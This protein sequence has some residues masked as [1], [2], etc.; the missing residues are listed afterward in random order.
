MKGGGGGNPGYVPRRTTSLN[1]QQTLSA[2]A[3]YW[4]VERRTV[5]VILILVLLIIVAEALT[6]VALGHLVSAVSRPDANG[7]DDSFLR[8]FLYAGGAMVT[9]IIL[10]QIL[11]RL[12]NGLTVR[13][14]QRLQL[15]LFARV[16]RLSADWHSNS[17]TGATVHRISRARWALDMMSTIIIQRLLQP[18][19]LTLVFGT[20]ICLTLPIAGLAFFLFT[21]LYL[22]ASWILSAKWVRPLGVLSAKSDSRL[23]GAMAD[24][25]TNNATVRA[26][27]AERREDDRLRRISDDWCNVAAPSFS[28]ATDTNA[29]QMLLWVLT[30]LTVLGAIAWQARGQ[31]NGTA[32]FAFAI[33]A[34]LLLSGQLRTLGQDIR[35]IQRAYAELEDAAEFLLADEV[36]QA[37][38]LPIAASATPGE[39]RFERVG[40]AYPSGK[41]V[42]AD[43]SFTIAAGEQVALVGP[44]GSGKSTI[45]RLVQRLYVPQT[46]VILIDGRD[47]AQMPSDY[48][49]SIISLVPQEPILFHRSLAENIAYGRPNASFEEI[50][51]AAKRARAHDFIAALEQGYDSIV[52]E[53]GAKLSG[54]E[55]QRVAIARAIL[56]DRPILLL[57]EATSS[58]DTATERQVQEAIRELAR[59]RTTIII[60]HRLST[61]EHVDR[62]LVFDQGQIVEQGNHDALMAK[63]S[64][65]YRR[66]FELAHQRQDA[67][68]C[69]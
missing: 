67:L 44:S 10:K 35:V 39:I 23:T 14:M 61:V 60:A 26:F 62:I 69:D 9:A 41:D 32:D 49:G 48:L 55:R 37:K 20:M 4:L 12:W 33:S 38:P 66:S 27:A 18:L 25:I 40:F 6:P 7:P 45:V 53:R 21:S 42:Y 54:G 13:S 46:G 68:L 16:Q 8:Y 31:Q 51:D 17:F 50:V 30:Q 58:L 57:D 36:G 64:G 52:G 34:L 15:D 29:I 63:Q 1:W 11:D 56:A 28:R 5:A 24:A 65:R 19:L 47:I 2:F 59:G 43:L 22:S 3:R